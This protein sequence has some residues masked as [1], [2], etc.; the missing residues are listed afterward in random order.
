MEEKDIRDS[1][2]K[3]IRKRVKGEEIEV[4]MSAVKHN[5]EIWTYSKAW[6]DFETGLLYSPDRSKLLIEG[7]D[8]YYQNNQL[9]FY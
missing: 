6:L 5:E 8:Y 9:L 2:G 3:I 7:E 4:L 1:L